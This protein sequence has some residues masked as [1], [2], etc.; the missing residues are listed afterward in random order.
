MK[1]FEAD[2]GASPECSEVTLRDLQRGFDMS[3]LAGRREC[4]S[5]RSSRALGAASS[6]PPGQLASL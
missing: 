5:K 1:R 2:R 4:T 3:S 6:P